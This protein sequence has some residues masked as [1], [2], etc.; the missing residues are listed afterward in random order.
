MQTLARRLFT[1]SICIIPFLPMQA[2][3]S[4]Q[5][6]VS[7][8]GGY[9]HTA[10]TD[11][12]YSI[13]EHSI[14]SLHN[15]FGDIT[16]KTEWKQSLLCV[17]TTKKARYPEDLEAFTLIKKET[18]HNGMPATELTVTCS[19]PAAQGTVNISLIV[20]PHNTL[21]AHTDEG[22]IFV[23][24]TH[25]PLTLS[26]QNGSIT[27]EN[28]HAPI[29]GQTQGTGSITLKNIQ[30]NSHLITQRGPITITDATSSI[31][32]FSE[33]GNITLSYKHIPHTSTIQATSEYANITLAVP[34][35]TD[36]HV[37]AKTERGTIQSEQYIQLNGQTTKL[38]KEAWERFKKNVDGI[39]GTGEAEIHLT[40]THGSIKIEEQKQE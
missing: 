12:E 34:E 16:V 7:F 32:A 30:G 18:L 26:S 8:F 20:P 19:N 33:R 14:L 24:D 11:H 13:P 15:D 5:S 27:A 23:N 9:P 40:T 4:G 21:I 10:T 29:N 25:A 37:R 39:M 22:S 28:I 2:I 36:A 3:G 38:N 1:L 31:H 35:K 6:I 17:N